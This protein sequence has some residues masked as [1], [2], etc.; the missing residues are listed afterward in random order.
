MTNKNTVSGSVKIAPKVAPVST[1]TGG[2]SLTQ[3]VT[4]LVD[5]ANLDM[6]FLPKQVQLVLCALDG[7]PNGSAT[8]QDIN[9]YFETSTDQFFW[10]RSNGIAYEQSPAK[11]TAHYLAKM[12]GQKEWSNKL[13]KL[14]VIKLS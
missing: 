12:L 8:M 4:L 7:T 9:K 3:K 14:A 6:S 2:V 10:G 11:I 5:L 1:S 13:G